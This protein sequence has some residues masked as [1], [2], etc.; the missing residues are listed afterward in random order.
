VTEWEDI[1]TGQKGTDRLV[2]DVWATPLSGTLQEA[3]IE[4]MQFTK[5]YME[6]LGIDGDSL[7]QAILGTN[8]LTLLGSMSEED[9]QHRYKDADLSEEMQKIDG[10]PVIIDGRYFTIREG[11]EGE[12][13]ENTGSDVKKMIGGFAKKVLKKR[14]KDKNEP[15]FTYYTEL[16]EFSLASVDDD[17]FQV[18]ANYKKKNKK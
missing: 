6:N 12:D 7:Q 2:T 13:E 15:A 5:A 14:S 10:Y 4:E 11:G 3:R 17:V 18:P 9:Q 1:E 8:W 16:Q